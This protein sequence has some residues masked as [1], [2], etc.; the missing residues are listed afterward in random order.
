MEY[1]LHT[2]GI[3]IPYV[4]IHVD[5]MTENTKPFILN[6]GDED[7]IGQ[8]TKGQIIYSGST[9]EEYNVL[10]S[11]FHEQK[12][13]IQDLSYIDKLYL[14]SYTYHGDRIA[15]AWARGK[16]NVKKMR[17][18]FI[19]DN[20]EEDFMPLA[21][22]FYELIRNTSDINKIV[23]FSLDTK[24][25]KYSPAWFD[26]FK[27]DE[28]NNTEFTLES[29]NLKQFY[30]EQEL[31]DQVM[32]DLNIIK[33]EP[34]D[35]NSYMSICRLEAF[36]TDEFIEKA[37]E[38]YTNKLNTLIRNAP[39]LSEDIHAF[40]GIKSAFVPKSEGEKLS[41]DFISTS[42]SY[43]KAREFM[44]NDRCCMK[45][46][47][48]KKGTKCIYLGEFSFVVSESEILLP[49]GTT[50]K[51]INIVPYTKEYI[52]YKPKK[53]REGGFDMLEKKNKI[54]IIYCEVSN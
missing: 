14:L 36:Y 4:A 43:P 38:Y 8:V 26:R 50:F 34:F 27:D 21:P 51:T 29:D 3:Q 18:L 45:H 44:D 53:I 11:W 40:R 48:I 54:D 42:L 30:T 6:L 5:K 49:P 19:D 39:P 1:K 23:K 41:V 28:E 13:Y 33:T 22:A 16:F 17:E 15:N 2:V 24:N 25:A 52:Y 32:E 12:I 37:V 9:K 20:D 35:I 10:L 46:I 7:Y 31:E 47:L